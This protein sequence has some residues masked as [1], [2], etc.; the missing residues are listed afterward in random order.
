MTSFE[1]MRESTNEGTYLQ[2]VITATSGDEDI[3][4]NALVFSHT[5]TR[6]FNPESY[7][8]NGY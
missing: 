1:V 7:L 8:E 4:K 2:V 3:I 6:N 5:L